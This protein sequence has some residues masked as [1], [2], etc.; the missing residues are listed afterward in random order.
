MLDAILFRDIEQEQ[1][2]TEIVAAGFDA[3]IV[4]RVLRL[5]RISEWKRQQS[6]PGPK[7]SRRAF[8]R[9]R[10]YPITSGRY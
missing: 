7:V 3:A 10:R 6:A 4:D 5:V 1:S 8:D 9:E 2:R